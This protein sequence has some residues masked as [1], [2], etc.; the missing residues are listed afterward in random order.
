V[1]KKWD[2][3]Q[4]C[5]I[6][7]KL[8]PC[9]C[10]RIVKRSSAVDHSSSPVEAIRLAALVQTAKPERQTRIL[11]AEAPVLTDT[12]R[13]TGVTGAWRQ[14]RNALEAM[15][16]A[17]TAPAVVS[18][19][20]VQ[21]PERPVAASAVAAIGDDTRPTDAAVTDKLARGVSLVHPSDD[22][23]ILAAIEILRPLIGRTGGI[24]TPDGSV[25]RLPGRMP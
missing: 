16:S 4:V 10:S 1:A 14:P 15:R 9:D 21:A 24:V 22:S 2:T 12:P 13:P 6:C 7:E 3:S 8:Q 19:A 17:V 25:R 11:P 23:E 5:I 18:A 20:P